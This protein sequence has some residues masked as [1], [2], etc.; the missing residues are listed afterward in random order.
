MTALYAALNAVEQDAGQ[1]AGQP[2]ERADD[3]VDVQAQQ[4]AGT[5]WDRFRAVITAAVAIG[6]D[7]S[8][9]AAI[10]GAL[11]GTKVGAHGI[12]AAWRHVVHDWPGMDAEDL[13]RMTGA[14]LRA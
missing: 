14:I 5:S 4:R 3:Q 9:V 6:G 8:T 12:P 11:L 10:A 7:T 2:T 1:T 13:T